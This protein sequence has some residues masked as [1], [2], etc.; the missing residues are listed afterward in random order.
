[1]TSTNETGH[2]EAR[3]GCGRPI[4]DLWARI[5]EPPD[6]H[7]R[8]CP[9]C[10]AARA[11]LGRLEEAAR[12]LRT[13]DERDPG[14]QPSDRAKASIMELARAEVR[15]GQMLPLRQT[16]PPESPDLA[17]SEQSVATLVRRTADGI[18]GVMA[19]RC[20]VRTVEP[21]HHADGRSRV[22]VELST[23]LSARTRMASL[24]ADLRQRVR[25]SVR[26]Q[27]GLDVV[28]VDI[29]VEDVFDA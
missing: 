23:A 19:R 1:M 12:D 10:Q 18:P 5:E 15:R 8:S 16:T 22:R 2:D 7:E 11:S 13:S 17:I 21:A 27:T 28:A 20:R 25:T 29:T 6:E 14:M 4:D 26:E 24:A 3:L 9:D